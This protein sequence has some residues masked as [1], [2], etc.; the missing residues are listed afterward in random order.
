MVTQR[1]T[2]FRVGLFVTAGLLL[3]M[4]VIFMLGGE[5]R[6]FERHYTIYANFESVSG[7]RIGAPVQVAGL[8]VGYVD[9]IKVPKTL[10]ERM[11]TVVMRIRSRYQALIRGD[12]MATIET[13]GLLGDKYIYVSMGSEAQPV[14]AD[15]GIVPSEETASIFALAD[16]AGAIMD[17]IGKAA[18]SLT[19][20]LSSVKGTK[21]EGDLKASIKSIRTTLEQIEKGKGLLHA[22]IFDPKGE[23]AISD[24]AETLAA[25]RDIA[26]GADKKGA[27]GLITNLR[28]ASVDLKQILD[29][30]RRGEG[31]LGKLVTDPALYDDLRSLF[32]KAN[33]NKLL[34]AVVRTTISE[35][36]KQMETGAAGV[37]AP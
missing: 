26:T 9:N 33:R 1:I 16:K 5:D 19:E 30:I 20:M 24:L 7:L 27:S 18:D 14:I 12:S 4:A 10:Q 17:D 32:G 11:M 8:R 31:T 29:Q 28:A 15:K 34:R 3:A 23:R 25:T 37:D 13:Q 21:G 2:D 35:N 36:D 6:L 22:V